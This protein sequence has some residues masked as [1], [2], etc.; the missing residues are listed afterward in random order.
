MMIL[1]ARALWMERQR[2]ARVVL[3]STSRR[4]RGVFRRRA[5]WCARAYAIR[6]N[7]MIRWLVV[8]VRVCARCA[9]GSE[10]GAPVGCERGERGRGE[11][12]PPLSCPSKFVLPHARPSS[13]TKSTRHRPNRKSPTTLSSPSLLHRTPHIE[14]PQ[15]A[16]I[17]KRRSPL[18]PC[19][20]H[21]SDGASGRPC[22]P[23]RPR[24]RRRAAES[25]GLARGGGAPA[26][27][28][29]HRG[30]QDAGGGAG[31]KRRS[32]RRSR[33]QPRAATRAP[34]RARGHCVI[35]LPLSSTGGGRAQPHHG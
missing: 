16:Q 35:A 15:A 23:M 27:V 26:S 9:S 33:G 10:W 6:V 1:R 7:R 12:S 34:R 8:L 21:Q 5:Y 25:G 13:T 18:S 22:A 19:P 29:R 4:S 11:P 32:K 28:A 31:R 14:R 3:L 24:Q 2:E 17:T 30:A 20:R